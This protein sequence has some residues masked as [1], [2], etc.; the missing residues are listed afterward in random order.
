MSSNRLTHF[1]MNPS[2]RFRCLPFFFTMFLS[3]PKVAFLYPFI[4]DEA[5][6]FGPMG[7]HMMKDDAVS[8]G[9]SPR[10]SETD[11]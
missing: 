2:A 9:S 11:G 1:R 10:G 7:A 4:R 5:L 6:I 8:P 3:L